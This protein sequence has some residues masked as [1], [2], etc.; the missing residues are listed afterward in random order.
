MCI[1]AR[2]HVWDNNK[3]EEDTIETTMLKNLMRAQKPIK[4]YGWKILRKITFFRFSFWKLSFIMNLIVSAHRSLLLLFDAF[5]KL[6]YL[7]K[8]ILILTVFIDSQTQL[9]WNAHG[10]IGNVGIKMRILTCCSLDHIPIIF[11]IRHLV[12]INLKMTSRKLR[13]LDYK[14]GI[15]RDF[16]AEKLHWMM[17]A[18]SCDP[19][20]ATI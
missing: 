18:T 19:K 14:I 12:Y 16:C 6:L 15:I 13:I 20:N 8:S 2:L 10:K 7:G 9:Q 11:Q 17:S 3:K 5:V 4:I 1:W